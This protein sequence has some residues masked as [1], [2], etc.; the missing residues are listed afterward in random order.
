[1]TLALNNVLCKTKRVWNKS[2]GIFSPQTHTHPC[3]AESIDSNAW[4]IGTVETEWEENKAKKTHQMNAHSGL[5]FSILGVFSVKLFFFLQKICTIDWMCWTE[6]LFWLECFSICNAITILNRWY[7]SVWYSIHMLFSA[8]SSW[9]WKYKRISHAHH[10]TEN[11]IECHLKKLQLN[12][13][14]SNCWSK[15]M[16]NKKIHAHTHTRISKFIGTERKTNGKWHR[17]NKLKANDV[18]RC[19]DV[20]TV[21]VQRENIE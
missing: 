16:M 12:R 10:Y 3:S 13:M 15:M 20:R 9:K 5:H 21:Q 7:S 1:M 17:K 8:S 11:G 19:D 4:H 2:N 18:V 14:P 6:D